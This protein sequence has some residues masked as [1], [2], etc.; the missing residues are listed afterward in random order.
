MLI[1]ANK[2]EKSE[3]TQTTHKFLMC[4]NSCRYKF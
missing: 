4:E 1:K 2:I 3:K